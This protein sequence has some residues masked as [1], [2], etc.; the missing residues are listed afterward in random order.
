MGGAGTRTEFR[1]FTGSGCP[2]QPSAGTQQQALRR[3]AVLGAAPSA[4]GGGAGPGHPQRAV[5]SRAFV[6]VCSFPEKTSL[7]VL[8]LYCPL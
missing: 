4:S 5:R 2:A 8:P 7:T 6:N 1:S 3:S